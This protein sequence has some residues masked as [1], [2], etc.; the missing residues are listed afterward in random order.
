MQERM[1]EEIKGLQQE[2][3]DQKRRHKG[4]NG[5]QDRNTQIAK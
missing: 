4:A 2:I 5:T 1:D 3:I